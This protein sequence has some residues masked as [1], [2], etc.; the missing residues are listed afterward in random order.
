MK[1][2]YQNFL[3]NETNFVLGI[4]FNKDDKLPGKSKNKKSLI[5]W[6]FF[7]PRRYYY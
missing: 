5:I 2:Y 7:K 4:R 6:F 1:N 3:K